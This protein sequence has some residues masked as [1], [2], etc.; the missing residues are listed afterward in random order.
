[1]GEGGDKQSSARQAVASAAREHHGRLLAILIK[2]LRDFQLAEDSLQD[3]IESA[4]MH[5]QRNGP[6]HSSLAWLLQVARRK[7]LDRLR[8]AKNFKDK[9]QDMIIL[10]DQDQDSTV[11]LEEGAI[12]DERLRLIFT[13]CHP[14]LDA[15][16]CVALSLRTLCGLTT[17]EIARAF[18]VS[19]ETMAQRLVRARQKISKAAIPYAV[20]EEADISNRLNAVLSTIYLTFNEGY[21]ATSGPSHLR[22]DLC[23]EAIRLARLIQNLCPNEPEAAGLLSLVLLTHA[24][25]NAR[26]AA[27]GAYI[28]LEEQDRAMWDHALIAE[29][30]ALLIQTL[31]LGELGP[32]QLQASINAVHAEAESHQNTNWK[33]IIQLY[34]KLYDLSEN[35]VYLLNRAIALSY[36]TNLNNGLRELDQLSSELQHYQPFHAA[37]A[38][39][40]RREGEYA[41]ARLAYDQ[42]ITLTQ[43]QIEKAFLQRRRASL[44]S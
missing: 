24:R 18:V 9:S 6:P 19:E 35:P 43:N 16:T 27:D 33:E 36:L 30:S 26:S 44:L 42:A 39:L 17:S 40:L 13:C 32:Y 12:P 25:R 41:A 21:A 7:A 23:E 8:R 20:P 5:W 34:D 22:I 29:G 14:A 28:P 15:H 1:L 4:L 3:A 31:K 38:D 2:E 11:E 10:M 37:R